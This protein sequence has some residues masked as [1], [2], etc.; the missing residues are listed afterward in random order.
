M[1]FS[2][3]FCNPGN[4]AQLFWVLHISAGFCSSRAD[5]CLGYRKPTVIPISP[6]KSHCQKSPTWKKKINKQKM[7]NSRTIQSLNR[8]LNR[9]IPI[10]GKWEARKAEYFQGTLMLIL[11]VCTSSWCFSF[12]S[13]LCHSGPCQHQIRAMLWDVHLSQQE[14]EKIHIS[15]PKPQPYPHWGK[16]DLVTQHMLAG[17]MKYSKATCH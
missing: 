2:R 8:E 14:R 7:L 11:G 12:I 5:W 9:I 17:W 6:S 13:A 10:S 15:E 1:K 4:I 16:P 3:D